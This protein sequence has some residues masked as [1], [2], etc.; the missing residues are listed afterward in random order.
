MPAKGVAFIPHSQLPSLEELAQAVAFL[1]QH[2][3]VNRVKLTGGE[4]LVRKGVVGLVAMLAGLSGI[5]E[6][7]M[8]TTAPAC[9]PWQ[10]S[11]SRRACP[12]ERFP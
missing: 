11:Q 4:P 10:P 9:R 8:T 3:R 5:E 12:R 6:V 2:L 1:V 7:S